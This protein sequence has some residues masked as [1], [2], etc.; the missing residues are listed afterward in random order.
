M[1]LARTAARRAGCGT[2]GGTLIQLALAALLIQVAP[3]DN[4]F[5]FAK[6]QRVY[7]VAVE[8]SSRDLSITRANLELERKAKDEFRKLKAFRIAATLRD[9]DFV[10]FVV[11]DEQSRNF[12]EVAL[13]VLPGDY[14]QSGQKLDLL[15]NAA[16]WQ[17]DS[18]LKRGRHAALAGATLGLSPIFDRPSVVKAL[19]KE[20]HKEVLAQP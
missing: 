12:D 2:E 14:E 1:E 7:V 6:A 5:R 20:F 4:A 10:F 11:F 3:Q 18:H 15:R 17:K 9:A 19:V 13:A 16:V 8:V